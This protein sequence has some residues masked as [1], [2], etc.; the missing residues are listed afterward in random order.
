MSKICRSC[1]DE[2][3]KL[4]I[5][6]PEKEG[7]YK[8][9]YIHPKGPIK[10]ELSDGVIME[11]SDSIAFNRFQQIA[12]DTPDINEPILPLNAKASSALK[13]ENDENKLKIPEKGID[14]L[15][16]RLCKGDIPISEYDEISKRI[17]VSL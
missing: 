15:N 14:I 10:C 1:G 13:I 8:E 17:K 12:N 3:V 5:E 11:I 6:D 7:S 4:K 9:I 2:L 16:L